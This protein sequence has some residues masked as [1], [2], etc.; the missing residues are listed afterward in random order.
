M[1]FFF[2]GY[3]IISFGSLFTGYL[4]EFYFWKAFYKN[5]ENNYKPLIFYFLT[6][7]VT[8]TVIGEWIALFMPCNIWVT[9]VVTTILLL[10]LIR[11]RHI[12]Q[13]FLND[14]LDR[15]KALPLPFL[16]LIVAI[17]IL[18]ITINAGPTLMDDT[19]SYH[20]QMVKWIQEYGS[21]KGIA[22]L[23]SRYG[24]NSA[25]FTSIALFSI[26]STSLNTYTLLNGVLSFWF[27]GHLVSSCHIVCFKSENNYI[28]F[29]TLPHFFILCISL[30]LWP[31]IRG[32]VGTSNYDIISLVIVFI[33]FAGLIR[34]YKLTKSF[35]LNWILFPFFIFTVRVINYPFLLITAFVLYL[36]LK[37]KEYKIALFTLISGIVIISP[38]LIRN[39]FLSGY[40]FYPSLAFD[41][42]SVDWK[43][44]K[45]VPLNLL[46]FIK[47]FNRINDMYLSISK[48]ALFQFPDWIPLWYKYLF[49]Y[50]KILVTLL[51]ASLMLSIFY[52]KKLKELSPEI[53]LFC[54]TMLINLVSWFF[55][56]P[57]PR[58]VYGSMLSLIFFFLSL[59][60]PSRFKC[61][62]YSL[63]H[64]FLVLG[65]ICIF[66]TITKVAG[67]SS[68]RN[69][70]TP[71]SLIEPQVQTIVRGNVRF[72]IPKK[73]TG[74]WNKRCYGTSLPCLYE[75]SPNVVPRGKN[76]KD[77]FRIN[78]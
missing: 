17:G 27:C 28:N 58:F 11:N 64:P 18:I 59:V 13:P 49:R 74:N 73:I 1:L 37:H 60:T 12:H 78:K 65:I 63:K 43:V 3:I 67:D 50:D 53:K 55:I 40:L 61:Y 75:L 62:F 31:I 5:N 24:F 44:E 56:A 25:W 33:L 35:H 15:S 69:W 34:T 52:V 7:L 16:F 9:I 26:P 32:G 41:F 6:G 39:L 19:E 54:L 77:G 20:I 22:N 23:H 47:Y 36:A 46:Y 68:Y 71:L 29:S 4:V 21:P 38:F 70:I 48:T 72:H 14:L 2:I 10:L 76:I 30:L 42:F 8:L 66:F 51:G 57:D 45:Q